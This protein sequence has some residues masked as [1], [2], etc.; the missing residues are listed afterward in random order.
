MWKN[1]TDRTVAEFCAKGN[2]ENY[3]EIL[4]QIFEKIE[5]KGCQISTR[6]DDISSRHWFIK[7][8]CLIQI[9]FLQSYNNPLDIIWTILHEFGHHLSGEPNKADEG[10]L[11]ILIEREK[12]AWDYAREELFSYPE[13]NK[14]IKDFEIYA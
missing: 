8:K 14:S 5:N 6:E 12:L 3:K 2:L 9:S 11:D 1:K 13:L 4:K 10:N 7:E